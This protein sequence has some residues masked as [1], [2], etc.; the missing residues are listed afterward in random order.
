MCPGVWITRRTAAS[1]GEDDVTDRVSESA[2]LCTGEPV[3]LG[4]NDPGVRVSRTDV[5]RVSGAG[6]GILWMRGGLYVEVGV[7]CWFSQSLRSNARTE[8]SPF[9]WS[10]CLC[11]RMMSDT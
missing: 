6:N 7:G 5:R 4:A 8:G 1:E 3:G 10:W 9:M 11:V 2:R